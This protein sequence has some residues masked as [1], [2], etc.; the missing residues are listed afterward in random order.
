MVPI[1][2]LILTSLGLPERAT[3]TETR[4]FLSLARTAEV[5]SDSCRPMQRI[6][7]PIVAASSSLRLAHTGTGKPFR[8]VAADDPRTRQRSEKERKRAV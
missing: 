4:L 8:A 7:C 6:L 5:P 1:D 2:L 3:Q